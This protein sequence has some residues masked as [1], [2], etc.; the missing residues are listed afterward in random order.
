MVFSEEEP[1]WV[2][3][4]ILSALGHLGHYDECDVILTQIADIY[5]EFNVKYIHNNITN[6]TGE[7]RDHFI[8]GL[9]KARMPEN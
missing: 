8:D 3:T 7:D 1:R 5:P 9:R 6:I 2:H 4:Y